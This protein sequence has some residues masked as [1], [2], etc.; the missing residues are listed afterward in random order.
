MLKQKERE[1]QEKTELYYKEKEKTQEIYKYLA[2]LEKPVEERLEQI[3][4]YRKVLS[5]LEQ[6]KNLLIHE[7]EKDEDGEEDEGARKKEEG[8]SVS[9]RILQDGKSEKSGGDAVSESASEFSKQPKR[10]K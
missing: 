3:M 7:E 6:E 4:N 10:N 2:M 9:S 8:K 5:L 1:I